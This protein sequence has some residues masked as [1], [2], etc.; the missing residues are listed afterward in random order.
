LLDL[1][2]V[3]DP[4]GDFGIGRGDVTID[5]TAATLVNGPGEYS[6]VY[7]KSKS[8][9]NKLV[10]DVDFSFTSTGEVAGGAP[11]FSIPVN[12]GAA[13][14]QYAFIDVANCGS[15]HVST[16]DGTCKVFV[17]SESFDNWNDMAN[18]HSDWRVASGKIP[19]VIADQPGTYELTDIALR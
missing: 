15:T 4:A 16:N 14:T 7:L 3:V 8:Q 17:G 5:G 6:G 19:F 13:G 11:R 1:A 2:L 9:S 12:T 18:T 10:K